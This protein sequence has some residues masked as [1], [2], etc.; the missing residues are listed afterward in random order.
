[1]AFNF[2]DPLVNS[3][4]YA[5]EVVAA[6]HPLYTARREPHIAK[7]EESLESRGGVL[8]PNSI[9]VV[10]ASGWGAINISF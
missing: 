5:A 10:G 3:S 4:P 2:L 1:M 8:G 7:F 9:N 6:S